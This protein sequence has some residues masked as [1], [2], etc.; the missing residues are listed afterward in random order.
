MGANQD[1]LVPTTAEEG[2]RYHIESRLL[3]QFFNTI[4]SYLLTEC[5]QDR[6]IKRLLLLLLLLLLLSLLLLL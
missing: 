6:F 1:A 5:I 3:P 4:Q 2:L